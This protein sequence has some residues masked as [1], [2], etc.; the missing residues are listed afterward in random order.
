MEKQQSNL[1]KIRKGS[2]KE[3]IIHAPSTAIGWYSLIVDEKKGSFHYYPIV[4][5]EK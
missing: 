4:K 1:Y 2:N 3:N 5:K